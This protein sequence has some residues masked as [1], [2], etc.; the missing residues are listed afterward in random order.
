VSAERVLTERELN[1]TML[2]RQLLLDR[3]RLSIPRT[4]ERMAGL[5]AQYA[6]SMYVGLWTRLQGLERDQLTRGLERRTIVQATL[7]RTTIHLVSRRDYWPFEIGVRERRREWWLRTR[8]GGSPGA[9]EM[10]TAARRLRA[11]M[12]KDGPMRRKE[13][14]ALIGNEVAQGVGLW[15]DLVRVP[16]SGTWER[17]RADLYGLAEEWV[18][19]APDIS[20]A[21]A[22]EHLVRRYLGGFGPSTRNEIAGWAGV[23]PGDMAPV[24]DGMELRRFRAEDGSELLDLPRARIRSAD[25]PAP[26]RFLPVWE[27]M[28]LVHARRT[29]VLPEHHRPRIFTTSN[30]QSFNTFLVDG[31]VAGAWRYADGRIELDP[32]E[33]LDRAT[34]RALGEE[35]ERLAAFLR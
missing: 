1:R 14:D 33:R 20:R 22:I 19:P 27:A 30:P 16:P 21:K 15:V 25:E 13:M 24:L 28:L 8:R 7:M 2:Y 17:R 35:A 29:G 31:V 12:R 9:R 26:V 23:P 6:P 11:R 34:R 4:L 32:F 5:Q 3:A 18:G 10:A